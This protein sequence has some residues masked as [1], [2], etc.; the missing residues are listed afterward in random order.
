MMIH[1]KEMHLDVVRFC[2]LFIQNKCPYNEDSCFYKHTENGN[3]EDDHGEDDVQNADDQTTESVFQNVRQ[4]LEPP[5]R[6]NKSQQNQ[7]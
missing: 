5:L 6:N 7:V 3:N 1:R 2:N 4:N